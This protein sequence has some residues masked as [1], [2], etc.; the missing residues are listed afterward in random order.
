[1]R[2]YYLS[3]SGILHWHAYREEA[4][5]MNRSSYSELGDSSD[6]TVV[7]ADDPERV[8]I[9]SVRWAR[10]HPSSPILNDR[11][12]GRIRLIL[13][14]TGKPAVSVST[15]LGDVLIARTTKRQ[16]YRVA[17]LW[18][19]K[20]KPRA[21]HDY[22]VSHKHLE[23]AEKG[24]SLVVDGLVSAALKVVLKNPKETEQPG[25]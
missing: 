11:I 4:P 13:D 20:K 25:L 9:R 6:A 23:K 16:E 1:M 14:R 5:S 19:K 22:T 18:P 24:V 7:V 2:L 3:E 17:L 10:L 12:L 8:T 21:P 15:I